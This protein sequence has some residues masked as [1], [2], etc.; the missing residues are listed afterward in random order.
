MVP[1]FGIPIFCRSILS[2]YFVVDTSRH[3]WSHIFRFCC[4]MHINHLLSSKSSISYSYFAGYLLLISQNY[5]ICMADRICKNSDLVMSNIIF[6]LADTI[7]CTSIIHSAYRGR[8]PD[9]NIFF[10][11]SFGACTLESRI[12]VTSRLY[13]LGFFQI[14]LLNQI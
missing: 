3:F 6:H 9:K 12:I 1:F 5:Q 11:K 8:N 14:F 2:R 4:A 10:K 13:I 7:L